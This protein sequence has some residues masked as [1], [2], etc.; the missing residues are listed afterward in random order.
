MI[1][2]LV[3]MRGALPW[4][5]IRDKHEIGKIKNETSDEQLLHKCAP[6]MMRIVQ[7]LVRKP[8]VIM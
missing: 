3:E 5:H 4:D 2:L 1:F 7:H 6:K 8:Q